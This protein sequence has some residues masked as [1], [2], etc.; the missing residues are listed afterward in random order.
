LFPDIWGVEGDKY[1]VELQNKNN[2][3]IWAPSDPIIVP[4][5]TI[6]AITDQLASKE[7]DT[8]A[9]MVADTNLVVGNT[10]RTLG[11]LAKGDGGD[12]V[13]NI[14]A[15][16]TGTVNGGDFI[17]LTGISGQANG[18]FPSGI[19]YAKQYGA[20]GDGA[21][22]DFAALQNRISAQGYVPLTDGTYSISASLNIS[23]PLSFEGVS[24]DTTVKV[25]ASY[26]ATTNIFT[27]TP[28]LTEERRNWKF[29]NYFIDGAVGNLAQDA[30]FIDL[31]AGTFLN[32]LTI[33]NVISEFQFTG[34]FIQLDNPIT[35]A[36][37]LFTG[38]VKDCWALNGIK[39][40][41]IGDSF[42]FSRNTISGD[43]I[44]VA[45]DLRQIATAS[46]IIIEDGNY[47]AS[48]GALF[49]DAAFNLR[50]RNN[51]V[52]C[53]FTFDGSNDAAIS[54]TH[55]DG[56]SVSLG[57]EIT[58]NNVNTQSNPK[59]CIRLIRA[60]ETLIEGNSLFCNPST[61][62]HITISA[63]AIDTIIGNNLFF[64]STTGAEITPIITDLGSGTRG[65]WKPLTI[66]L[67]SWALIDAVN[68]FALEFKKEKDGTVKLRGNVSGPAVTAADVLATLPVGFRPSKVFTASPSNPADTDTAIN[69][70]PTGEI[71]FITTGDT[72]L[73]LDGLQ[74]PT[75]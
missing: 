48:G 61:G 9:L 67:A 51:Q 8:V 7:F 33:E 52:E 29:S 37:G 2:I 26:P 58:G 59:S 56:G 17:D 3:Q 64:S 39:L 53:P 15:A 44:G 47:T 69:I 72:L 25:D 23:K 38:V 13:Y 62:E 11:Y 24:P 57:C 46:H 66:T 45:F 70:L 21:T 36:D 63:G 1:K 65:I 50:F 28:G 43:G 14:V 27:I 5:G 4:F 6:T 42:I 35:N 75:D 74:F 22:D 30:F 31:N 73:Y 34:F 41:N 40:S 32:K 54:I 68:G 71:Q 19:K 10:V 20:S 16:A 55:F 60:Q 49:C 18:L 12:N